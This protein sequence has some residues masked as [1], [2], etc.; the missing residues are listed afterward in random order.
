MPIMASHGRSD[1]RGTAQLLAS[2]ALDCITN[3]ELAGEQ[4]IALNN[5]YRLLESYRT[6]PSFGMEVPPQQ[7]VQNAAQRLGLRRPVERHV[8]E[9]REALEYARTSAFGE[10]AKDDALQTVETVL[11]SVAYPRVA[12]AS[13]EDQTRTTRFFE[14]LVKRL[15]SD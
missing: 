5:V 1:A 9:V 2:M 15:Q 13:K 10:I 14:A 7:A 6:N 4:E 12:Y 11:R 3:P 8:R